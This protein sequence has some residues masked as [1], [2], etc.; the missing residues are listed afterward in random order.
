[1]IRIQDILPLL[2]PLVQKGYASEQSYRSA[3]TYI[4]DG[5]E[6]ALF[7][8][9]WQEHAKIVCEMQE[10]VR[11]LGGVMNDEARQTP[12]GSLLFRD[13][14]GEDE[15][16]T[17]LRECENKDA[18]LLEAYAFALKHP[19]PIDVQSLL[20]LHTLKIKGIQA[21]VLQRLMD[22]RSSTLAPSE[23]VS[24]LTASFIR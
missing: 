21:R 8:Y 6:R 11:W 5:N 1:M 16:V 23:A 18:E 7:I 12:W 4:V 20:K 3:L 10:K 24:S 19:M 9:F 17:V 13:Q 2:Q 14:A 22:L 15:I